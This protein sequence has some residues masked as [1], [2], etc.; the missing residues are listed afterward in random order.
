M[1][2]LTG[3]ARLMLVEQDPVFR[4]GL[5]NCLGRFPEFRVVA[6]AETIPTAWR[7]LT[8]LARDELDA[9]LI[10]VGGEFAQQVKAQ[11]PELSVLVIEPLGERELFAAFQAGIEGY[12]PKGSSISEF[13]AAVRQITTG[14]DYWRSEVLDAIRLANPRSQSISILK[15]IR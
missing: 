14:Q 12:C 13:V 2:S 5:L 9:V 11:Y 15:V 7:K 3:I 4:S 6:E 1:S 10:G 8:E